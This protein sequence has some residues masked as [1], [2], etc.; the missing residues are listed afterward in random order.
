MRMSF[1]TGMHKTTKCIQ[2]GVDC[3]SLPQAGEVFCMHATCQRGL[4][5]CRE[6]V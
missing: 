6:L 1:S 5:A 3:N 2:H 4:L